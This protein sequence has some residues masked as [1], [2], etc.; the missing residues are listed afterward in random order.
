MPKHQYHIGTMYNILKGDIRHLPPV[1]VFTVISISVYQFGWGFADPFFSLYLGEFSS[2]YAVIGLFITLATVMGFIALIPLGALLDRIS[3]H[4]IIN[5]AKLTYIFIGL[6]YFCA[7]EFRSIPILVVA[8]L[9]NGAFSA[10]VWT[11]TAATIRGKSTE[12]NSGLSFGFYVTA[13]RIMYALGL[14]LALWV[15]GRFP[16]HYIFIPVII[17]PAFSILLSQNRDEAGKQT[18]RAALKALIVEDKI[19]GR[20]YNDVKQF[21]AEMWAMYAM[22]FCSYAIIPMAFSFIP[23]YALSLGYNIVEVGLITLVMNIPFLFS[24]IS[25]EIADRSERLRNIIIGLGISS[26][27]LA[28]LSIW[29]TNDWM[30]FAMSFLLVAGYSIILPSLSS[31]ITVMTP[32]K[33][34]GTSSAMIDMTMFGAMMVFPPFIGELID[35]RGWDIAF[36]VIGLYL[37]ILVI[38]TLFFQLVFK[39]RNIRYHHENPE[40]KKNPYVL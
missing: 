23:L 15:V 4:K 7:G 34:M 37:G 38:M 2:K 24:F 31:V 28:L 40:T 8:L 35:G 39:R 17:F 30:L 12:K 32:K 1:I 33:F 20:V 9:L 19:V 22:F 13:N 36:M 25:A 11:G 21:N 3:H 27:S 16:I 14:G 29:H 18:V 6:A 26:I 5:F 10:M